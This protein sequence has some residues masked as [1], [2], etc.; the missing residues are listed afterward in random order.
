M[1]RFD[2]QVD[3][4]WDGSYIMRME[5]EEIV[6]KFCGSP[7]IVRNGRRQGT[8][9]WLCRNCGRGFVANK[10]LPRMKY[11]VEDISSALYSYFAGSSLEQIRGLIEQQSNIRPSD[12]AIYSWVTKFSK[13]AV[14]EAKIYI[15]NVGSTWVADETVLRIEGK[16]VWFW[17]IIDSKTRFLLA[18]HISK[19][20]TIKDAQRLMELASERAGKI[21]RVVV[22]DKLSAYIDG[23]ELTFGAETKHV[24]SK[25][26]D[27]A[28]LNNLIERFHGTLKDRTKVLRGFKSIRTAEEILQGWLFYYNFLRPHESLGDRT[29]AEASGIKF[30]HKNWLDIVRNQSPL[31]NV[32]ADTPITITRYSRYA[33]PSTK[34]KKR[35]KYG[36][37]TKSKSKT[38]AVITSS[39]RI[40]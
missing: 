30:P 5:Y 37:R 40:K 18:S 8:Q 24:Q 1:K 22:T 13:M 4:L 14:D 3:S 21:P 23:I 11:S 39:R 9:Y 36:K 20:R 15:P 28:S 2:V 26:F 17:D 16:N 32:K 6:C 31:A 19:T 35:K 38:R 34:P 29:P 7:D 12:S 33:E 25:P 10:A 27:T